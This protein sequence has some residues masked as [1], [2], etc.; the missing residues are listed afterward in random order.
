MTPGLGAGTL[1]CVEET[2]TPTPKE[3]QGMTNGY[4]VTVRSHWEDG[5][6]EEDIWEVRA[7]GFDHAAAG[8]KSLL[9]GSHLRKVEVLTVELMEGTRVS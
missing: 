2:T 4:R 1:V 7:T 6:T 8:A 9:T 5:S 3:E